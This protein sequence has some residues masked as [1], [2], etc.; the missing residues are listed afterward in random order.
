VR[1]RALLEPLYAILA[2][3]SAGFA[4][5]FI[6]Q[7]KGWPYH[8]Y[9][10]FALAL[11]AVGAVYA[12][13][14]AANPTS[15]WRRSFAGLA[16]AALVVKLCLWFNTSMDTKPLADAIEKIHRQPRIALIGSEIV[17]GHPLVRQ[18]TGTWVNRDLGQWITTGAR[19][20]RDIGTLDAATRQ[21]IEAYEAFDRAVTAEDILRG[22]PDI[23]IVDRRDFDWLAWA[24]ADA[25][26]RAA[27]AGYRE[28]QSI[29]GIALFSRVER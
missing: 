4:L 7:G 26:T 23:V 24:N 27:L 9:P 22:R 1:P 16:V 12:R 3:A 18:L 28:V 15:R 2:A 13:T 20:R 8:A 19:R 5:S 29:D 6:A 14:D 25:R 17:L 11:L 10:M 21:R